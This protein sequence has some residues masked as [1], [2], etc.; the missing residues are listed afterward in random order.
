M[1][2]TGNAGR[3]KRRNA[4]IVPRPSLRES[5]RHRIDRFLPSAFHNLEDGSADAIDVAF[6]EDSLVPKQSALLFF[7]VSIC[8]ALYWLNSA[9]A[10]LMPLS[11]AFRMSG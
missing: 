6:I 1:D 5:T 7:P 10:S 2:W 4:T 11:S 3:E 8:V 9:Q